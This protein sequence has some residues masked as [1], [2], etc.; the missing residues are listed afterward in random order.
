MNTVDF[1]NSF[2]W[3]ERSWLNVWRLYTFYS[4][5]YVSPY[6]ATARSA[7]YELYI[8]FSALASWDQKNNNLK[9]EINEYVL[10]YQHRS[11]EMLEV[12]MQNAGVISQFRGGI[13][14]PLMPLLVPPAKT[15]W[16]LTWQFLSNFVSRPKPFNSLVSVRAWRDSTQTL[17]LLH[18]LNNVFWAEWVSLCLLMQTSVYFQTE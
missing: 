4:F 13:K 6:T 9:E 12:K 1:V 2:S 10:F 16:C 7:A 14:E 8:D 11:N 5:R 15:F 3:S 17:R 18:T